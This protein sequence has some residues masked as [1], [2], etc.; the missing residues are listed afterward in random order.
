[1]VPM[2]LSSVHS[3]QVLATGTS[4]P[5]SAV[6]TL[7]SR[8]TAWALGSS[9]PGGLR[10]ITYLR[11]PAPSMKVGLDCP[12]L[13]FSTCSSPLKPATWSFIHA[14]R[15]AVSRPSFSVIGRVFVCPYLS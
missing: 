14:A 2:T 9:L 6:I 4:V 1:M 13:N 11:P 5:A 15:R 10:R 12:P 7:Y 8:S 3:A